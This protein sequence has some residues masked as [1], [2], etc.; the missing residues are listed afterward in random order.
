MN[1]SATLNGESV[2]IVS[3]DAQGNIANV[4]YVDSANELRVTKI[5][6]S[7]GGGGE[8]TLYIA[9]GATIV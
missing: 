4:T 9:S 3:V 5:V 7:M 8:S 6:W 1:V 2:N